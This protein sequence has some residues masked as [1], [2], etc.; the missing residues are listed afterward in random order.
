[1]IYFVVTS[2][3]NTPYGV[4][5][6]EQRAEQV[7]GTC[8]RLRSRFPNS[9]IV[10]VETSPTRVDAEQEYLLRHHCDRLLIYSNEPHLKDCYRRW[11]HEAIQKNLGETWCMSNALS[12][13]IVDDGDLIAKISGR[14]NLT[15]DFAWRYVDGKIT[16]AGPSPTGNPITMSEIRH[17]Y[18]SRLVY[19]GSESHNFMSRAYMDMHKTILEHVSAG[20]YTDVEHCLFHCIPKEIINNTFPGTMGIEGELA[21]N[22]E[23]VRD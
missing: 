17:W 19:W 8:D 7:V 18:A 6:A 1:M 21:P 11:K 9:N 15:E 14:Y 4:F 10:L 3:L 22:G 20:K 5:T 23:T 2:A 12:E 16:M 13:M